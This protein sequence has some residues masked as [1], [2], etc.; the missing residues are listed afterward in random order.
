MKSKQRLTHEE[1]VAAEFRGRRALYDELQSYFDD[2]RTD[3]AT[4]WIGKPNAPKPFLGS[5]AYKHWKIQN[6]LYEA[7]FAET[8][9]L[10]YEA[11]KEVCT[12]EVTE[13]GKPE[14]ESGA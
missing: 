6:I 4:P 3:G 14:A 7:G 5:L 10:A 13:P 8:A 2:G 12:S 1:T 9:E 11:L